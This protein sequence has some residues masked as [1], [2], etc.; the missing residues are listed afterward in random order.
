MTTTT[1]QPTSTKFRLEIDK[2]R[3]I[4]KAVVATKEEAAALAATLPKGIK[5][6]VGM[7]IGGG[8]MRGLHF[9]VTVYAKLETNY[10]K[11]FNKA[12]IARLALFLQHA[13]V[14]FV[15]NSTYPTLDQALVALGIIAK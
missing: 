11:K 1:A 5:T 14:E 4:A 10:D 9:H 6:Y 3:Y 12:G 15:P 7:E 8:V 13:E 2:V